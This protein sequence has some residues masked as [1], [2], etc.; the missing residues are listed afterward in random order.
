MILVLC[1]SYSLG[2][3]LAPASFP[4]IPEMDEGHQGRG[5]LSAAGSYS[6]C[7][8]AAQMWILSTLELRLSKSHYAIYIPR[9][10]ISLPFPAWGRVNIGKGEPDLSRGHRGVLVSLLPVNLCL[11]LLP[12]PAFA[13]ELRSL[14]KNSGSL[15][16]I[17]DSMN[18]KVFL[19]M[20]N[21]PS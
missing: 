20:L 6:A 7:D 11:N 21:K 3:K 16:L 2:L 17:R 14:F 1:A 8:R 18:M 15:E 10:F 19:N 9:F 13:A 4:G 12:T 5:L